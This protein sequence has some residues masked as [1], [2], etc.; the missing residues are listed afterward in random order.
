M[1]IAPPYREYIIQIVCYLYVVLFTYAAISKLMDFENF[2]IQLGQSPLLS[3]FTWQLSLAV[4]IVELLIV[5]F[6]VQSKFRVAALYASFVLMV[7]FTAYI[8]ILLNYAAYVPC[9]CSGILEKLGWKEHIIFNI[10]YIV[11]ASAAILSKRYKTSI[12]I[13]VGRLFIGFFVSI[14]FIVFLFLASE[15]IIYHHNNFTRRFPHFPVSKIKEYDL[16]VNSYYFSGAKNDTIYLGNTTT[17]L[18]SFVIDT[19]LTKLTAFRITVDKSVKYSS[20]Q[21]KII[22]PSFYLA[23][24]NVPFL[25]RGNV[26][27][28]KASYILRGNIFF[29]HTQAID[30][31]RIIYRTIPL[32]TKVNTLGYFDLK[33]TTKI[34]MAPDLLQKQVDGI[35]DTEG[36]LLFNRQRHEVIYVY[37]YRNE[38]LNT[39][40]SLKLKYRSNTIDTTKNAQIKVRTLGNTRTTKLSEPPL[41]VNKTS[42]TYGNLLFINS[43]LPGQ[44]EP[45][46]MWKKASIIDV[47]DLTTKSYVMSFYLYDISGQ[48][49]RSFLIHGDKFFALA[50]NKLISYKIG[51]ELREKLCKNIPAGSGED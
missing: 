34:N 10:I 51:N 20:I 24:G 49:V 23:D 9:S 13:P 7:L 46:E 1:K 4:P 41:I 33:D 35:F 8:F 11:L 6:L 26:K 36:D 21:L 32:K 47:Y 31:L 5:A 2:G 25:F 28:W 18:Q 42:A 38:Y 22:P 39:D 30:S 37:R 15:E 40:N 48:K 44:F 29:S 50:G 17:P 19:S 43:N 12:W 3:A 16:G 45:L 27:D 14:L